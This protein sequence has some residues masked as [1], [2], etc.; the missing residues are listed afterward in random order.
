MAFKG[1]RVLADA[2]QVLGE[3]RVKELLEEEM[4]SQHPRRTALRI[5]HQRYCILRAKRERKEIMK[6]LPPN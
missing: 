2:C 5:L 4:V 1:I 3:D 6:C